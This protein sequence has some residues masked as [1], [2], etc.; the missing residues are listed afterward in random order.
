MR[1]A[2]VC[3]SEL[4]APGTG[5]TASGLARCAQDFA[6]QSCAD[7]VISDPAS[8]YAM[9]S[10]PNDAGCEYH[11]QC[12]STLCLRPSLTGGC[13][14]CANR[15][16]DGGACDNSQPNCQL[17]LICA[18]NCSGPAQNDK[19][20]GSYGSTCVPPVPDGGACDKQHECLGGLACLQDACAPAVAVGQPC[21]TWRDCAGDTGCITQSVGK[22]VCVPNTH[23]PIDGGCNIALNGEC[24]GSSICI[25]PDGKSATSG[26][27][28]PEAIDGKTCTYNDDCLY[29]ATCEQGTCKAPDDA[30]RCK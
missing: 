10:L 18:D 24:T 14:S 17:G 13:G 23:S 11:S 20:G 3:P 16:A 29:P 25:G 21:V 7:W 27:C 1:I 9:G 22:A 28:G 2:Q 6:A 5:K 26:T 8:C 12:Q 19:C 4:S 30:T 15:V